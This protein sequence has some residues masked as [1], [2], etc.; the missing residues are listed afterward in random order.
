MILLWFH[1]Q[2]V[3]NNYCRI[4]YS[5]VPTKSQ[6]YTKLTQGLHWAIVKYY[7]SSLNGAMLAK[8]QSS[9]KA[10]NQFTTWKLKFIIHSA[11]T[12]LQ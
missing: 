1:V 6:S 11:R 8:S 12:L 2:C 9:A 5:P 4:W 10:L 7:P 3:S